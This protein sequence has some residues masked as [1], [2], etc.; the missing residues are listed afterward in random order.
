MLYPY[1]N[2]EGSGDSIPAI[3]WLICSLMTRSYIFDKADRI[4]IRR[5]VGSSTKL[6]G[7][8]HMD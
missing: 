8:E 5:G 7:G 4:L 6:G 3:N 1:W 2:P